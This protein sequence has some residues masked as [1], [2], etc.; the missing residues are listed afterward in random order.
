LSFDGLRPRVCRGELVETAQG[1]GGLFSHQ[2]RKQK[3]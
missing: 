2:A 1:Y 3:G